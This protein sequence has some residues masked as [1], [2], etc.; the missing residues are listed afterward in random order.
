MTS[1]TYL[2]DSDSDETKVRKIN[3]NLDELR[4]FESRLTKGLIK[5][6][7]DGGG[8][9]SSVNW[10]NIEGEIYNQS[11][12]AEKLNTI[13]VEIAKKVSISDSIPS[14]TIKNLPI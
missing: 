6:P 5:L 3:A 8:S 2:N 7:T 4:I 1:L 11:D 9:S 14:N 12:L 13:D 10:G